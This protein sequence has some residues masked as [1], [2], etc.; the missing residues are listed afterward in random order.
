MKN[1]EIIISVKFKSDSF[2]DELSFL[3]LKDITLKALIEAIYYGLKK[4]NGYEK[5]FNLVEKYLKTR[6]ELQVLYNAKGDFN[7]IDFTEEIDGTKIFNKKLDELGFVTSSCVLFTTETKV[8]PMPLF[9]KTE[10]SYILKSD[11]S[12]EYNISTRRLNVIEPSVIE[13]IPHGEMPKKDKSSFLDVVIPT[14]L[15]TGGMLVARYL[16][17]LLAP[18]ASSLGN[19]MILMS[20]AMGIVALVTTMYNF[21]RQRNNYKKDVKVWKE[22][23]ENYIHRIINRIK[24]WQKSDI[25]YLNSVYPNMDTLFK[26]TAEINSSIF[27]RSQNDND[28]MVISLGMSDEVK[29]LFEIKSEKK[30]HIFYDIYYKKIGDRIE[31]LIPSKKDEK[32]RKKLSPDERAEEDKNKFMLT[33]LAYNFANKDGDIGFKY[34]RSDDGSKPPLLL[35]LKSCGALGVISNDIQTSKNFIQHIIFELAYYHSPEDLQFVFFFEQEDDPAKQNEILQNYKYL[36]HANELFDGIS[37][38]VFDKDSAGI[39]FG[40]LLSIMNERVKSDG[41]KNESLNLNQKHTQIVCIVF[42]DYNIKE[43]GFSKFLPE[44][45]KEGEPYVNSNGLTFIFIQP[46]KD[47]LPKY[48]GNIVEIHKD[49]PKGR[50]CSLRYNILSRETLNVLSGGEDDISKANDTDKIIEY[51]HFQN[52]YIFDAEKYKEKFNLAFK[53]LS[54]IYYTR[55]AENGKVPSMVTLFELY[56]YNSEKIKKGELKKNILENWKNIEKNDVTRNLSVAIGKNEHGPIYLDLYEKADGPHMLVAGTT[57]SGKSETIITYLIGLCMKFSPMDLNLM[58]VDMK[59]GGFSDRLGNLPHCVGVVTDTAGEEEGTSAAYMLKR[60][61]ESLNAEIK[62]RKLLLSSLG[63]DNI[64]SYIRALRVIRQIK[65]LENQPNTGEAIEK[66]KKKLNEKQIKALNKDLKEFSYLSH[67]VLVVDEF[68]ELKRFSNESNDTDFIAEI[69]TIARVGRTLGFHIILV[70]QNIEGAI[71]DDIRVN[72]KARICL[73]V[74]TKQASKEMIGSPAAA[75]PTM[76]LNG[77]AY[78]LVGT[79]TRFEYFQSAYTGSNKNLDIEAPVLV[80]QVPNSGRFNTDF[81]SS[82]KD[83][84]KEKKKNENINE[85]DTQL[86]YITNTII[87]ISRDME[88]PRQIFLPP[89]PEKIFDE[90]KW[91]Y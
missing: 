86:R 31:I 65:E 20:A 82:K 56:G 41:E 29:P 85:H 35:D 76:P 45:P 4:A 40:Q 64:D 62:R 68:T 12:L 91:R 32:R 2:S 48:C 8:I 14:A 1:N 84:E 26:N 33:D 38:F 19:T 61:L 34:L 9:Q 27:S 66:L 18:R 72:S 6:K 44:V 13:I 59:G 21:M 58:L 80:T 50:R 25:K 73:K 63:V 22:N 49:N 54:A 75:A 16:I 60:F 87:E 11:N 47:K 81:Y 90:T 83:N 88:K 5:H 43:T 79:G 67:L 3:V 17:M 24:E 52:D 57:G 7:I 42:Y 28:F 36:P 39:V 30:D 37:Q 70:S 69:T 46:V 15:S 53:Q 10:N 71:T 89:L 51:K 23:Y 55:I 77:R 74:A 78:L